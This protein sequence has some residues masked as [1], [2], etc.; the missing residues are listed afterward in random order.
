MKIELCNFSGHKIYPGK[1]KLFVRGDSKIFRF[2]SSKSESYFQQRLKPAKL[3]WTVTFRRLHKKGFTESVQKK[4]VKR[5]QKTIR[6][7]VGASLDF[8]KA[9]RSGTTRNN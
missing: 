7:V 5:V 3:H 8:I 4:K 2:I 6:P 1:G 9:K